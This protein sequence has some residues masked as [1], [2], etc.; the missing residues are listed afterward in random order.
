MLLKYNSFFNI[1][2]FYHDILLVSSCLI[3]FY[4]PLSVFCYLVQQNYVLPIILLLDDLLP[5][6]SLVIN[7]NNQICINLFRHV[8]SRDMQVEIEKIN[9]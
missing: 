2:P 5:L 3:F 1:Y 4:V 6:F 9:L 7:E 8:Q